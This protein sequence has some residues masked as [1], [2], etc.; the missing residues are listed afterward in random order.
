MVEK[1]RSIWMDGKLVPW[2]DAK[3]HVLT[4]SLHY[5]VAAFEGI[6]SY[7]TH[8]GRSAVF[9]L[10]DHARRLLDSSKIALLNC[11]YDEETIVEACRA[12]LID[13]GLKEGYVRPV[14]Y[15]GDGVIGVYPGDNPIRMFI[16][17]W[18]WGAYLG[19]DAIKKGIRAKVSSFSRYQPNS[20]MTRAKLTGNYIG[21]VLAK[22]EAK[23][24]G[25]DEAILLDVDGYVAEG[26]GEN[27][28]IVR[29]GRL[30]TTP[31]TSILP[32]ITR[33]TV[34][35]LARDMGLEVEEQRFSRDELYIADEAFF[36]G[37]AAEVTPIREVD[38]RPVGKG[39]M[40]PITQRL[41]SAYFDA[42]RGRAPKYADW[43]EYY[44][45]PTPAAK[46][47]KRPAK[48]QT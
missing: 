8:D 44:E 16:A 13:N 2:D 28:F 23:S 12:T 15:I 9:R 32:G 5:G 20:M 17:V 26:S 40:G 38:G 35:T 11:P 10:R 27:I 39:G 3:V 42:I 19:P 25:F 18:K 31:L 24:L 22:R 1:L 36:T 46:E 4:H 41:Q 47:S 14:V 43:L 21:S 6:R 34:M 37:T 30:K 29:K 45:I 48:A 7:E 33:E